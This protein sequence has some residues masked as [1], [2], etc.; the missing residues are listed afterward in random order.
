[1]RYPPIQYDPAALTIYNG[2]PV[3][4]LH[5]VEVDK[6]QTWLAVMKPQEPAMIGGYY[7]AGI[8]YTLEVLL[9]A[10]T[11]TV[12]FGFLCSGAGDI[13]VGCDDDTYD[14]VITI[15]SG[16]GAS[17]THSL[18]DAQ[19]YWMGDALAAA[20]DS[21]GNRALDTTFQSAPRYTTVTWAITDKGGSQSL[22]VY[23]VMALP[24]WPDETTQLPA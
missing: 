18:A 11:P 24:E 20:A 2:A 21:T 14:A 10:Y 6:Y 4:S 16:T 23:T 15:E 5:A 8:T 19:M 3:R 13:T 17:G 7:Q 9:P 22:R 1:M 12:R